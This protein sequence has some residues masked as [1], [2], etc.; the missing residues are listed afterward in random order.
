VIGAAVLSAEDQV[1]ILNSRSAGMSRQFQGCRPD[2]SWKGRGR[3]PASSLDSTATAM[4][5]IFLLVSGN[6]V[7]RKK[8]DAG[9]YDKN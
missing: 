7:G 5:P 2:S 4:H 1:T 9:R 8:R 6:F 3:I